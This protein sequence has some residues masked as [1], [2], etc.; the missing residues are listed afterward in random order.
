MKTFRALAEEINAAA[1]RLGQTRLICVDG[2]A[3]SGKTTFATRLGAELQAPIVHMDD[4]YEGWD[5]AFSPH[6]VERI[7]AWIL[8]PLRHGVPAR[9]LRYDWLADRFGDWIDLPDAPHLILEGVR[10]ADRGVREHAALVAWVES[11]PALRLD[12]V[13]DRDGE[14]IRPAMLTFQEREAEHFE[15]Q[16][17]RA[18]ADLIVRGDPDVAHTPSEFVGE[19]VRR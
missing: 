14:A 12:R 13:I 7:D 8:T 17:T 1:V 19:A 10:S 9:H 2:P 5:G 4:L 18:A 16:Q 15:R 11:A 3:G 6:L